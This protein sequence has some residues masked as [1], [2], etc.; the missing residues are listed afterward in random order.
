MFLMLTD[1]TLI[2]W[3]ICHLH[4]SLHSTTRNICFHEFLNIPYFV[5]LGN[6]SYLSDAKMVRMPSFEPVLGCPVPLYPLTSLYGAVSGIV[7]NKLVICGGQ[8]K[9][10]KGNL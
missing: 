5:F 3:K 7:N 2:T 6:I 8:F 10:P 9:S 4:V 1:I